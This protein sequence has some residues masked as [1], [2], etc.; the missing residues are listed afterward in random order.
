MRQKKER[1]QKNTQGKE[2]PYKL[3]QDGTQHDKIREGK[4][5]QRN[6]F[7]SFFFV[8]LHGQ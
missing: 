6:T 3:K 2:R 5:R 1:M 8:E 4:K 7:T